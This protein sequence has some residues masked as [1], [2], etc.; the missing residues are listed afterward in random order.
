M[1]KCENSQYQ[2]CQLSVSL[3][4]L[5]I[6]FWQWQHFHIGTFLSRLPAAALNASRFATRKGY[7]RIDVATTGHALRHNRSS[8]GANGLA[9]KAIVA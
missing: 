2:C 7:A 6:G 3:L 5:G 4:E 8:R 9:A 1:W